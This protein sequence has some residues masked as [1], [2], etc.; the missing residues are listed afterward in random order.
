MHSRSMF[1]ESGSTNLQDVRH[2]VVGDDDNDVL[3]SMPRISF[4]QKE[5]LQSWVWA[6]L[7]VLNF[8]DR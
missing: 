3:D 8:G 6:T 4:N 2:S 7:I 1:R 5:N